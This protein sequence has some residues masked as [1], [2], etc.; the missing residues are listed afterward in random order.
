MG[1]TY[2]EAASKIYHKPNLRISQ[3]IEMGGILCL[4]L[5]SGREILTTYK[6]KN[7][8]TIE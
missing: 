6:F 1:F 4:L 5:N 2:H 7:P 3:S 8:P